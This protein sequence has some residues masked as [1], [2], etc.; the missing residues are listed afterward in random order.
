MSAWLSRHRLI[1][2][3]PPSYATTAIR[4][5]VFVEAMYIVRIARTLARIFEKEPR[6]KLLSIDAEPVLLRRGVV[7][8]PVVCCECVDHSVIGSNTNQTLIAR[9]KC[10]QNPPLFGR[11]GTS[12]QMCRWRTRVTPFKIRDQP[13]RPDRRSCKCCRT[14]FLTQCTY[15]G[16]TQDD[17][18]S[19]EPWRVTWM[20][21]SHTFHDGGRFRH[22]SK[23]SRIEG[24]DAS[25]KRLPWP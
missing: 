16:Y 23:Q 22:G 9:T 21:T 10:D 25:A 3:P 1:V 12:R 6:Q 2:P 18:G 5:S 19:S 14:V 17:G 8:G 11:K 13:F 20:S 24:A 7:A 15:T 4:I